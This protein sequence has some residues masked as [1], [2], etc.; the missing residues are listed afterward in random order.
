[1]IKTS[2]ILPFQIHDKSDKIN[3]YH[4]DVTGVSLNTV[5]ANVS[6]SSI[7]NFIDS[8]SPDFEK[9]YSIYIKK[10]PQTSEEAFIEAM[11]IGF[12]IGKLNNEQPQILFRSIVGT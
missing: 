8:K 10:H 2:T 3:F 12:A 9:A 4:I 6:D 11:K 5:N 7:N 1:M